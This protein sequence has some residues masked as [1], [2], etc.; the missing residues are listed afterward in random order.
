MIALYR[1][2]FIVQSG[3]AA[4]KGVPLGKGAIWGLD[5]VL[6]N[7]ALVDHVCASALTYVSVLC[8]SHERL[9]RILLPTEFAAERRAVRK[10]AIWCVGDLPTPPAVLVLVCWCVSTARPASAR[11]T[12]PTG[13][14]VTK[15]CV[16]HVSCRRSL[17]VS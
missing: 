9:H 1:N 2:L 7:P 12:R 16:S 17:F 14:P 4:R 11:R 13:R 8:L 5:F 10:A 3:I 6:D 15:K